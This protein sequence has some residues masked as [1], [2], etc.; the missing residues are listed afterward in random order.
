MTDRMTARV[1]LRTPTDVLAA[2]PYLFGF[3]PTESVVVIGLHTSRVVFNVRADLPEPGAAADDVAGL[4]AQLVSA[5]TA[6]GAT[7][8][9]VVGYGP[10]P[11]VTRAVLAVGE[12]LQSRGLAICEMLRATEGRYWSYLCLSPECCP[13]EGTPYD[14]S[15]TEVA[16]A[17]TF[18]GRVALPDRSALERVVAPPAGRD[19]TAVERATE[20]AAVALHAELGL[21]RADAVPAPGARR[22]VGLRA[23]GTALRAY[24]EGGGLDDEG[25]AFLVL[26]VRSVDVRDLACRRIVAAGNAIDPH[27]ELWRDATRRARPD[28]AA[29]PA[30]LLAAAAWRAGDGALAAVALERAFAAD[31]ACGL[32]RLL[33]AA[34]RQA[35]PPSVLDAMVPAASGGNGRRRRGGTRAR[36]R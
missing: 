4:A 22:R 5:L 20:R 24:R 18:A 32:A 17:A 13:P 12:E 15:G 25:L 2:V 34:L 26:L 19:L 30:S 11:R 29:A 3:H 8:A 36:A 7:R 31:P 14:T 27:V 21:D 23:L 35:L 28:L 10:A 33:D 16:A 9:L 6:Q 1:T